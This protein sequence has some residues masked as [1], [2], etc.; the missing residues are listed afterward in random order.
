M[1]CFV[2]GLASYDETVCLRFF[3]TKIQKIRLIH[4]IEFILN[5]PYGVVSCHLVLERQ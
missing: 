4:Q 2:K 1:Y 5:S 3:F